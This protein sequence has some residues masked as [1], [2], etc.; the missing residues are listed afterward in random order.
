MPTIGDITPT[1]AAHVEAGGSTNELLVKATGTDYDFNWVSQTGSG[2]PTYGTALWYDNRQLAAVGNG[3]SGGTGNVAAG[4]VGFTPFYVSKE[5]TVTAIAFQGMNSGQ[6]TAGTYYWALFGIDVKT[7]GPGQMLAPYVSTTSSGAGG[8]FYSVTF[9]PSVVI[10]AGWNFVAAGTTTNPIAS[11][12]IST[13]NAY[14]VPWPVFGYSPAPAASATNQT[15]WFDSSNSIPS[16]TATTKPS[17]STLV[18]LR[19]IYFKLA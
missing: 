17:T 8:T 9:T 14:R 19:Q 2:P 3:G 16:N 4:S 15:A 11:G 7:L 18:D 1:P 10:P 13:T 12:I 6:G 5:I